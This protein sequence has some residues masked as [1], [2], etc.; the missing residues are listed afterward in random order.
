VSSVALIVPCTLT[1]TIC[2]GHCTL[3]L[4]KSGLITYCQCLLML[5]IYYIFLSQHGSTSHSNVR[6]CNSGTAAC[7]C[8]ACL[9]RETAAA[10]VRFHNST[11]AMTGTIANSDSNNATSPT[12][13]SKSVSFI[14]VADDSTAQQQQRQQQQRQQQQHHSRQ[15]AALF[16]RQSSTLM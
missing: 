3:M 13:R 6:A 2:Y 5:L 14:A 12:G 10:A 9:A 4:M 1:K 16:Q 8:N 7:V 11:T 15:S